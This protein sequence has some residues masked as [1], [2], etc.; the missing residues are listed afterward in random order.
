MSEQVRTKELGYLNEKQLERKCGELQHKIRNLRR[1]SDERQLL[2]IE[3]CY[4][5]REL[6]FRKKRKVA[7]QS[8][9]AKKNKK[10]DNRAKGRKN[11]V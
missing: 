6:E 1:S 8:F 10:R 11:V 5:F 4:T 9:L 3:F 7:H 2:E